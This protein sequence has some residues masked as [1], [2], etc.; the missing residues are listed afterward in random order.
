[1]SLQFITGGSGAGK[2]EYLSRLV[3]EESVRRPHDNFIVVV[4]EQYTMETQKKLVHMHSRKGILNID[5]VS[6]ERLAYKVFEELGGGNRPVLDDTGKNL[7]VR[8]VLEMPVS[9]VRRYRNIVSYG[10]PFSTISKALQ[11]ISTYGLAATERL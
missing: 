1:M 6:F 3:C 4:P 9:P 11:S 7:I 2:S 8:R 5:V 10:Y